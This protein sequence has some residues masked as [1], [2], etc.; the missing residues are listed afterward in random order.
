MQVHGPAR[1]P[2]GPPVS[3]HGAEGAVAQPAGGAE[4]QPSRDGGSGSVG[5][6]GG[7]SLGPGAG[8]TVR[9]LGLALGC[10]RKGSFP[11]WDKDPKSS[12]RPPSSPSPSGAQLVG[13]S[14]AGRWAHP[15]SGALSCGG[16]MGLPGHYPLA[17]H[18]SLTF[19]AGL[20]G[21]KNLLGNIYWSTP[22]PRSHPTRGAHTT[23]TADTRTRQ[24][25]DPQ[26]SVGP[27]PRLPAP[28][29]CPLG[30]VGPAA[31]TLVPAELRPP[32]GPAPRPSREQQGGLSWGSTLRG[33]RA[34][35]P[36][37]RHLNRKHGVASTALPPLCPRGR[38]TPLGQQHGGRERGG[39]RCVETE[40]PPLRCPGEALGMLGGELKPGQRLRAGWG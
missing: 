18:L 5:A 19:V 34:A 40:V 30:T 31:C 12:G 16:A 21:A 25:A 15:A 11:A 38:E 20:G 27:G 10:P 9:A 37:L 28:L 6:C 4:G 2:A 29:G 17:P 23:C 7:L 13:R 33:A 39:A 14:V 22:H 32:G 36:P 3:P 26:Y 35:G 24:L 1:P 8:T